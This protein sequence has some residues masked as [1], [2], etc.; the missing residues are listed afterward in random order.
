VEE[1]PLVGRN[2]LLVAGVA[3]SGVVGGLVFPS[4]GAGYVGAQ[5]VSLTAAGPSPS[6]LKITA[7]QYV[8]FHNQDSMTHTVVFANGLCSLTVTPGQWV[9]PAYSVNGSQ[10][11]NNNAPFYVGSYPYTVDDKVGGVVETTPAYRSV[12]LTA[13]AHRVRRGQ[14]LTLHGTAKWD[15]NATSL[16]NTAP[17][18]VIVLARY[19]GAHAFK[20]IATVTMPG[21]GDAQ[22]SWQLKV[23][24]GVATTYIAQ[25]TGQLPGGQIWQ[26]ATSRPFT[27]RMRR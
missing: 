18:P 6:T 10:A 9:G 19:P 22:G 11:C 20:P 24:A 12:T 3:L 27:I 26:Q 4:D 5:P 25:L 13:R 23:R 16:S 15:N 1:V 14:R 2:W 7:G 8:V 17:F 21:G